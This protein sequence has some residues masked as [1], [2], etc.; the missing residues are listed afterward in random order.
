M[1]ASARFSACVSR[2]TNRTALKTGSASDEKILMSPDSF[3][4]IPIPL[5]APVRPGTLS[6]MSRQLVL[7]HVT[8]M[9]NKP[10]KI[11]LITVII[12]MLILDLCGFF[13]HVSVMAV[14][15]NSIDYI[16]SHVISEISTQFCMVCEAE[17]RDPLINEKIFFTQNKNFTAYGKQQLVFFAVGN[18]QVGD[19][20]DIVLNAP[21]DSRG[22]ITLVISSNVGPLNFNIYVHEL[23]PLSRVITH[24]PIQS[25]IQIQPYLA[26][27]QQLN[28]PIFN[29][30]L[31]GKKCDNTNLFTNNQINQ[32]ND[33]GKTFVQDMSQHLGMDWTAYLSCNKGNRFLVQPIGSACSELSDEVIIYVSLVLIMCCGSISSCLIL[34]LLRWYYI[35]KK[36]REEQCTLQEVT[37][38]CT[39]NNE[40]QMEGSI[41]T[42]PSTT[43]K[44]IDHDKL[45]Q[46]ILKL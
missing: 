4:K 42:H 27:T 7:G 5:F 35:R 31:T 10:H 3:A 13:R 15:T 17:R 41:P 29:Y 16:S 37:S 24:S 36:A 26:Q 43:H 20:I 19:S 46:D 39:A 9:D 44:A 22:S 38:D 1:T 6:S 25:S 18:S 11:S 14:A 45:E 28:I 34:I 8:N 23:F 12:A 32:W 30:C 33:T 2:T 21:P 40:D